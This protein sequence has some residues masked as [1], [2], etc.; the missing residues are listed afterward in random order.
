MFPVWVVYGVRGGAAHHLGEE[1]LCLGELEVLLAALDGTE[2]V[3]PGVLFGVF[4]GGGGGGCMEERG[5]KELNWGP[6]EIIITMKH[7]L[8]GHTRAP[9]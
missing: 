9:S 5:R 7:V 2:V 1:F 6:A 4:G 3:E 8:N